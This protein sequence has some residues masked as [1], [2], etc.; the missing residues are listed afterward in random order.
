MLKRKSNEPQKG[1]T[2]LNEVSRLSVLILISVA[3]MAEKPLYR[4]TCGDIGTDP[5]EAEKV[6]DCPETP[7]HTNPLV[8]RVGI[9]VGKSLGLR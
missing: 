2:L 3:E 9:R 5:E 8:P 4:V 7:G 1:C 6:T